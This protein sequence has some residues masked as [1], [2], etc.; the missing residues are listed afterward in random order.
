MSEY[1]VESAPKCAKRVEG[2]RGL[3]PSN[4]R[5]ESGAT[6]SWLA[7]E[8]AMLASLTNE[9]TRVGSARGQRA[10]YFSATS[11]LVDGPARE[12]TKELLCCRDSMQLRLEG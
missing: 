3:H 8:V 1:S 7:D 4:S 11:G 6:F 12:N 2:G 9:L 5:T 10:R